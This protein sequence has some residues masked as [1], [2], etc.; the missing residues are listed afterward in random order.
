MGLVALLAALAMLPSAQPTLMTVAG[1]PSSA[2]SLR[3]PCEADRDCP[4]GA[5]RSWVATTV[6]LTDATCVSHLSDGTLVLCG[7][8][9]GLWQI[10]PRGYLHPWWVPVGD[11]QRPRRLSVDDLALSPDG[12]LLALVSDERDSVFRIGEDGDAQ[13]LPHTHLTYT[14]RLAGLPD[15]GAVITDDDRRIY[16]M[17]PQGSLTAV[18]GTRRTGFAGDGGPAS[19]ARLNYPDAIAA[20]PDG[21]FVFA[22]VNN[23]RIRKVDAGGTI[24]T[25]AGGGRRFRWDDGTPATAVHLLAIDA[26]DV[27]PSGDVLIAQQGRL[28]RLAT[29]GTLHT[30]IRP[31]AHP[32]ITIPDGF[33]RGALTI[34]ALASDA[35]A[36]ITG[37]ERDP[38]QVVVLAPLERFGR[39][40]VSL[41]AHDRTSVRHGIVDVVASAP[42]TARVSVRRGRRTV[43]TTTAPLVTGDNQ[44]AINIPRSSALHTLSVRVNDTQGRAATHRIS[45]IASTVLSRRAARATLSAVQSEESDI[46]YG[47][48]Y[49]RCRRKNATTIRCQQFEG[50]GG[51][52]RLGSAT[53][54]LMRDGR[55][56]YQERNRR[57]RIVLT[58]TDEPGA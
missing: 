45:F 44:V 39:L 18:A 55:I 56:R 1:H 58:R 15:G 57:G 36:L 38:P 37:Y 48:F 16:R 30:M 24:T 47:I 54:R 25:I 3:V 2:A 20:L 27:L 7:G 4:P 52:A 49:R 42:A 32:G 40:A 6:E 9:S 29:D 46:G 8:P 22:D 43:A 34:D 33:F 35:V 11:S 10:D 28:V 17:S 13:P 14:G 50:D 53:V 21:G 23:S 51:V 31:G 12:T 41:A 26:V 19:M 5:A